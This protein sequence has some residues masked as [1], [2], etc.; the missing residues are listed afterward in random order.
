MGVV[1]STLC[2]PFDWTHTQQVSDK[3]G[4]IQLQYLLDSLV[5]ISAVV[6]AW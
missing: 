3:V 5:I 1:F 4:I 2:L 6:Q